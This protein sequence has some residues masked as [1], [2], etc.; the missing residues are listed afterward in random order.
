MN[1][2]DNLAVSYSS[3]CVRVWNVE[4]LHRQLMGEHLQLERSQAMLLL[5][6]SRIER[7]VCQLIK[8]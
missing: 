6:N 7:Q 4:S 5:H 8:Y 3:Q 1:E 2:T